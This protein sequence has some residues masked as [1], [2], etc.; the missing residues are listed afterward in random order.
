MPVMETSLILDTRV[1][2]SLHSVS[3]NKNVTETLLQLL[4]YFILCL[5]VLIFLLM[6]V[7]CE[8]YKL[9]AQPIITSKPQ[10]LDFVIR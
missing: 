3:K 7:A 2:Y 10:R 8:Q 1:C 4:C 5:E 6:F 9:F